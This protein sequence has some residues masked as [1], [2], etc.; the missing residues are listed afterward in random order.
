MKKI[1]ISGGSSGVGAQMAKDFAVLGHQVFICGR[2]EKA[3]QQVASHHPSIH[4]HVADVTDEQ[5][6][7]HFFNQVEADGSPA[8]IVIANAGIAK[9]APIDKTTLEMFNQHIDVNLT[10]VFLTLR[11]AVIRLK[12]SGQDWGRL[13]AISSMTAKKG[14]PYITAYSASKHGVLGIVRSAAQELAKTNITVNAVCPGYLDT[15]MTA[16][17]IAQISAKTDLSP[18]QAA[19]ILAKF[20][21]QNRLFSASEVSGLVAY[22]ASDEAGG[23]TGQA[24]SLDGGETS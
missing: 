4:A 17:S 15:E 16:E 10:G 23:I 9:S 12:R 8:S 20:S 22:L 6:I 21:P 19:D 18:E 7:S 5:S 1:V 24:L 13:I 2:R 3:I 14:Y 11:E